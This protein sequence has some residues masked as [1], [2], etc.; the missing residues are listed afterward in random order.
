[1]V[2]RLLLLTTA[3]ISLMLGFASSGDAQ[4]VYTAVP[5]VNT[6]DSY[7]ESFGTDW[8]FSH[9]SRNGYFFFN[10]GGANTGI[11]A[12][13]GFNPNIKFERTQ[14]IMQG[15]EYCDFRLSL[16]EDEAPPSTEEQ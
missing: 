5:L 8:G 6:Q 4:Q 1:M 9:R 3:A 7:F 12:F 10:R 13:G 16:D 15:A 11:P 2:C 14:T